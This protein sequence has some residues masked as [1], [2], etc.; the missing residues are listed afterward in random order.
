MTPM[1][2]FDD[3]LSAFLAGKGGFDKASLN[4]LVRE[5]GVSTGDTEKIRSMLHDFGYTDTQ[6]EDMNQMVQI[7]QDFLASMSEETRRH[8]MNMALEAISGLELGGVPPEI[9]R[10]LE[11]S[12]DAFGNPGKSEDKT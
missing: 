7:A 4:E 1:S 12:N 9:I 2:E 8:I 10:F 11:T 6:L 3:L 5:F